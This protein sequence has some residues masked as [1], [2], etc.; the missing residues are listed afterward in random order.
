MKV[1]ELKT[2]LYNSIKEI[3]NI[4]TLQAIYYIINSHKNTS[5]EMPV[6]HKEILDE[7]LEDYYNSPETSIDWDK[8]KLEIEELL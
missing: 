3:D 5:S 7:R 2:S 4:D 1:S 6:F 8:A